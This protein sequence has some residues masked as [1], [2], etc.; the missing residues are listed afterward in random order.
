MVDHKV[1]PAK[2]FHYQV[3]TYCA[4]SAPL[5]LFLPTGRDSKQGIRNS[6]RTVELDPVGKVN[7]SAY[8]DIFV[9]IIFKKVSRFWFI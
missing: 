4:F 3:R 8:K 7:I 2:S 5:A 9:G 6:V 1:K